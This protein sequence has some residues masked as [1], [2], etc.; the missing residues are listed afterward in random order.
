MWAAPA[1]MVALEVSSTSR[2]LFGVFGCSAATLNMS[3]IFLLFVRTF[4]PSL[5]HEQRSKFD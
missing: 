4:W 3:L 5:C 2:A 1:Q